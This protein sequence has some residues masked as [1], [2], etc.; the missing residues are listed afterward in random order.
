MSRRIE[1]INKHIQRTLGEIL[2]READLPRDVMVTILRVDTTANLRSTTIYLSVLPE[3][4]GEEI[5]GTIK[6]QLYDLQGSLNRAIDIRPLPR[7]R[8]VIDYG[9][10]H[11]AKIDRIVRDLG[12]EEDGKPPA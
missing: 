1:K 4:R 11:S 8:L 2:Q 6:S 5:Y 12:S 3:D 9:S 7:I 10:A